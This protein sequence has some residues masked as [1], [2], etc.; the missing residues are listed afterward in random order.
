MENLRDLWSALEESM[1]SARGIKGKH[2]AWFALL[3]L[4]FGRMKIWLWIDNN[5]F[6]V[7]ERLKCKRA[8]SANKTYCT[9]NLSLLCRTPLRSSPGEAKVGGIE[10]KPR[11][12]RP[13][14][15]S[16][17]VLEDRCLGVERHGNLISTKS[18]DQDRLREYVSH[19]IISLESIV[20]EIDRQRRR[21]RLSWSN[22]ICPW[23]ENHPDL[24]I[25]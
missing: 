10:L 20:N 1:E 16:T 23:E 18:E 11:A 25:S 7:S 22:E 19:S 14:V 6:C 8:K 3:N 21:Q 2:A 5:L 12:R 9:L 15:N 4:D 13:S 24:G 17:Q